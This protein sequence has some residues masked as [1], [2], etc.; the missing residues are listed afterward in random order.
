M[1]CTVTINKCGQNPGLVGRHFEVQLSFTL[2]MSDDID[3][4]FEPVF[5]L[6]PVD[7]YSLLLSLYG[8]VDRHAIKLTLALQCAFKKYL[9][10]R[11]VM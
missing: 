2:Q 1:L 7:F 11:I 4:K 5:S 6:L 3:V 10:G 8:A 9:Q